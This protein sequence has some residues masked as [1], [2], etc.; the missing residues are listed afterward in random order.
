MGWLW[1]LGR[2]GG[3]ATDDDLALGVWSARAETMQATLDWLRAEY[4]GPGQY[5]VSAGVD[6][7]Q[8]A[9]LRAAVLVAP[10]G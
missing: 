7:D 3:L 8:L 4:G 10:T 2:P 1:T 9:A 6:A 5:L